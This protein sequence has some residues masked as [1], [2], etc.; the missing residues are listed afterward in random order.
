MKEKLPFFFRSGGGSVGGGLKKQKD[1]K[2]VGKCDPRGET[3]SL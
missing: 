1:Q 2:R 3:E